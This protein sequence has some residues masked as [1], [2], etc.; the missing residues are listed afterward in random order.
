M[1][2]KRGAA[3]YARL[4]NV[5]NSKSGHSFGM[6]PFRNPIPSQLG[7]EGKVDRV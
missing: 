2:T 5:R 4:G 3:L 1:L 7:S 6:L